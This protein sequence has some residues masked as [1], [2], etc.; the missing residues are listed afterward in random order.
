MQTAQTWALTRLA[1]KYPE[2]YRQYY[3][4]EKGNGTGSHHNALAGGRA[5]RRLAKENPTVYRELYE[6]GV[7]LG[8]P[9]NF[10]TQR[11]VNE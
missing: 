3:L 9:R 6:R 5:R 8:L 4:E 2:V 11:R 10:Y 1:Y 7:S